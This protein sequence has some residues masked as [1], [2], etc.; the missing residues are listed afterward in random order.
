MPFVIRYFPDQYKTQ[1]MCAK[2]IV[3]NGGMLM[4]FPDCYNNKKFCPWY[5][6]QKMCVETVDTCPLLFDSVP[7][8]YNSQERHDKVVSQDPFM[9]KYCLNRYKTQEM[10]N[11]AAD[12]CPLAIKFVPY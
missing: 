3:K 1:D 9:L 12:V 8:W 10:C 4:F 11:K 6:T 5:K 2:V 7:D